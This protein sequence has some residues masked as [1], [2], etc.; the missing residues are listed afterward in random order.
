M[1]KTRLQNV[2]SKKKMTKKKIKKN[3]LESLILHFNSER[4]HLRATALLL[5][6]PPAGLILVMHDLQERVLH[7][8][9]RC[10]PK[11]PRSFPKQPWQVPYTAN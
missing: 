9:T 8:K 3:R 7:R 11:S 5:I 1:Y 10:S 4:C 6:G 2:R